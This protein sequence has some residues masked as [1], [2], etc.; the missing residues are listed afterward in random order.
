M[1]SLRRAIASPITWCLLVTIDFILTA[2]LRTLVNRLGD[3]DDAMRLL[4]A[5]DLLHGAPWFDTT[6]SRIGAPV[7]LV[8]HWSRFVDAPLALLIGGLTPVLG[9]DR[10]ALV[11]RIVWPAILLFVLLL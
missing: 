8:S 5:R 2:N 1:N 3:P 4:S 7:A 9:V 6:L 11:T 10:A